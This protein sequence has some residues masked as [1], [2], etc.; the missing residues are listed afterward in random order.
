MGDSTPSQY[1]RKN[2]PCPDLTP[3]IEEEHL[4]YVVEL[5]S[6]MDRNIAVFHQYQREVIDEWMKIVH[7]RFFT[8][9]LNTDIFN[10]DNLRL[11]DYFRVELFYYRDAWDK[12]F[13]EYICS[14]IK[15][16]KTWLSH[17]IRDFGGRY[18]WNYSV[19]EVLFGSPMDY[20]GKAL[21]ADL[22][23]KYTDLL[24]ELSDLELLLKYKDLEN[25]SEE[26]KDNSF[27]KEFAKNV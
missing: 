21:L 19:K 16:I 22:K 13:S 17:I 10:E 26:L 7:K 20:R 4:I 5:V 25:M 8:E 27:V 6:V 2:K 11:M 9:N 12:K 3:I 18:E 14:D 15:N 1:I 23:A 24:P